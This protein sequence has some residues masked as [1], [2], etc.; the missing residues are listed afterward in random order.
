[1]K[2]LQYEVKDLLPKPVQISLKEE[3]MIS[4]DIDSEVDRA[5]HIYGY[6][7]VLAEKAES[8]LQKLRYAYDIWRA[9]IEKN[10]TQEMRDDGEKP[11]TV[12]Q[13]DAF[14]KAHP[15]YHSYQAKMTELEEHRRILK[16]IAKAFEL[17]SEMVRTKAANRRTEGGR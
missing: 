7:A 14:V 10:K 12:G 2:N 5:A 6:Y 17:K 3:L 1:M 11:Y 16:V 8:R 15:K 13:M 4:E 9:E